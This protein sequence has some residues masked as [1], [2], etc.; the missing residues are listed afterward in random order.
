MVEPERVKFRCGFCGSDKVNVEAFEHRYIKPAGI[1]PFYV[2]LDQAQSAFRKW[3]QQGW[4]HP[5]KLK[6]KAAVENLH[7]VYLPFW[8]YDAHTNSSWSGEAGYHYNETVRMN[9]N[10]RMRTQQVQK[11]RWQRRSGRLDHFFD[12]ILVVASESI[13]QEM[14]ERALPFRLEEV[15]NFDPRLMIGWES[16]V[17]QLEV[18]AGYE[19]ADTIMDYKIRHMC[20]AQLGGDTQRNLHVQSSKSGQTFKHIMLPIWICTYMYQNKVYRF[21]VNGQTGRVY[22]QK[23]LSWV[24]IGL[25]ILLFV[26][27]IVAIVWARES[28]IFRQ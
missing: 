7:G 20:S 17:Y 12:D 27:F 21:L 6:R 23:P 9:V 2:S 13:P 5:N 28:G 16:E 24:K 22:G 18:D 3:I 11:T 26:L 10:G 15:V 4:F 25:I 1:I 19:K 8:T 14:V